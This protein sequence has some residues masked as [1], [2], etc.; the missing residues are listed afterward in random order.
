MQTRNL[1]LGTTGEPQAA[2][3]STSLFSKLSPAHWPC[4]LQSNPLPGPCDRIWA[5]GSALNTDTWYHLT[6][7]MDRDSDT[8][9]LYVNGEVAASESVAG[10]SSV[11]SGTAMI[12][13]TWGLYDD[14]WKGDID[15][16]RIWNTAL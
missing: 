3:A 7:V 13:G 9:T 6:G 2:R 15:E 1:Q 10:F 5:I 12:I 16:V 8:A 4:T 14:Y 11:D